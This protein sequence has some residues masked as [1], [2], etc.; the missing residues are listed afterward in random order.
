MF[1]EKTAAVFI[2]CRYFRG[3]VAG[4][5]ISCSCLAEDQ[6]MTESPTVGMTEQAAQTEQAVQLEQN[7]QAEQAMQAEQ[8]LDQAEESGDSGAD[9]AG[10]G[11]GE[12]AETDAAAAAGNS[13]DASA[14][15]LDAATQ[16][17]EAAS[18]ESTGAATSESTVAETEESA[19]VA[20]TEPVEEEKSYLTSPLTAEA[21]GL[22]VTVTPT[23]D[24]AL[25]ED[26]QLDV[27][28][29]T[30]SDPAFRGMEE[31]AE[32]TAWEQNGKV[33]DM[34]AAL[35][36]EKF[37]AISL[38][39]GDQEIEPQAQ[40]GVKVELSDTDASLIRD[41][42]SFGVLHYRDDEAVF[43][44]P[45]VDTQ[46]DDDKEENK[47][48]LFSFRAEDTADNNE[49]TVLSFDT[50]SFSDWGFYYTYTVDFYYD[51][52]RFS[53]PGEGETSL[54]EILKK[55]SLS[56][57]GKV[58]KAVYSSPEQLAVGEID[59]GN[60]T[61]KSL[62]P[63]TSSET[64]TLTTDQGTEYVIHVMDPGA[65]QE[66][67]KSAGEVVH[68]FDATVFY[69]GAKQEDGKYVWTA[70]SHA[71]DHRFSY[72]ISFGLGDEETGDD[73]VFAP[74]T[75]KITVPKTILV[76]REDK[77]ADHY[78]MS[79]PSMEEVKEAE[80]NGEEL[81][82]EVL[83][84]YKEDGDQLVITNIRDI[85]PGFDGFIEMSY[86]TSEET[87]AYK[88]MAPSK[89]FTATITAMDPSTVKDKDHPDGVWTE[90]QTKT[91]DSVYIDTQ[92]KLASME[93]RVP[94]K[95][96][97]WQSFWGKAP[98]TVK[99]PG[100][101]EPVNFDPDKYT[102]FVYEI[103]SRI[104]DNSQEYAVSVDDTISKLIADGKEV[105]QG[106]ETG[107]AAAW[108]NNKG[109]Y[110]IGQKSSEPNGQYEKESGL[111]YDYVVLAFDKTFITDT[112]KLEITNDTTETVHPRDD[113][114]NS[115][116]TSQTFRRRFVWNKPVFRGGGGGFGGWVRADGFYRYQEGRDEWP[117]EY[118]TELGNHAG[119]YSGYNL[120]DLTDDNNKSIS[121]LDFA[122]W[123][124]GYIGSWSVDRDVTNP[125]N[126]SKDNYYQEPVR[127]EV[128][129]NRFYLTDE[130]DGTSSAEKDRLTSSDDYQIDT[131]RFN[132]YARDPVYDENTA[133]FVGSDIVTYEDNEELV[134][135]VQTGT[136]EAQFVQAAVYNL[137]TG[138]FSDVVNSIITKTDTTVSGGPEIQF[139]DGVVGY[140]VTT[141]NKHYY[142][143]LGMVPSVS[144]KPSRRVLDVNKTGS[145]TESKTESFSL[146]NQVITTIYD[147]KNK[148]GVVTKP[149]DP[150]EFTHVVWGPA[151]AQDADFIRKVEKESSLTKDIVAST[152]L[153]KKKE[154]RVTWK[155]HADESYNFGQNEKGY[156]EQK[157][158]TFYDLLP[159]GAVL[160]PDSVLI[161]TNDEELP[162]S[163]FKVDTVA[164]NYNKTGRTLV[165]I[166]VYDAANWYD[167]YYDTVHTYE[168]IRDYGNE[169]YN[170][171]AYQTGNDSISDFYKETG[172]HTKENKIRQEFDLYQ[173]DT[174]ANPEKRNQEESL[175]YSAVGQVLNKTNEEVKT[176]SR[177]IF[178]G[179]DGDIAAIT[180]AA[181]GLSKKILS[182]R[183]SRYD[184]EAVVDN[185]GAYHYQLRFQNSY[186]NSSEKVVLYDA[187]EN[188]N[189]AG[190]SSDWKGEL[191]AIDFS[192]LPKD[193]NGNGLISPAIYYSTKEQ[194]YEGNQVP[195]LSDPVW[196]KLTLDKN[197]AVPE[198]LQK[199]IRAIAI[200][201]GTGTD[202]KAYQLDRGQALTVSLTMKAPAGASRKDGTAG[203]PEA[204][205]GVAVSYDRITDTSRSHRVSQVGC[206][207]AKL[208]ISRDVNIEKRSS[209]D[210]TVIRGIRFRLTET[211]DYGTAVDKILSTD[212]N[213]ELTFARV[214]KGTYTLMEYGSVPDWLDD[215]TAYTVKIDDNGRLWI[216]NPK[217]TD[218]PQEYVRTKADASDSAPFWFTV[219]NDPRIH[220]D[221]RFYKARQTTKDNDALTGIPDTTFELSGTSDYGND[222]VKTAISDSNGLV[223]LDNIEK[224]TYTLREIKANAD[225]I[226][227]STPYQVRVDEAGT[228]TLWKPVEAAGKTTAAGGLSNGTTVSASEG[229]SATVSEGTD[230]S[231]A[232]AVEET[233]DKDTADNNAAAAAVSYTA[234]D[235]IGEQLVIF[236]TPAY[237]DISFLKV[238]KDLP[239]RTLQGATFQ[240][241]G[242]NLANPENAESDANG[243]VTF[244]HL[245]SGSYV[246]KEIQA[247]AG[248][249]GE[250]KI[251]QENGVLNYTADASDYLIELKED[252]T[253]TI[254]KAD[255]SAVD[256]NDKSGSTPAADQGKT[257][258]SAQT[259]ELSKNADGDYLFP[260]ERALDGQIT[261][262]KKWEDDSDNDHRTA[263]VIHL[264]TSEN[265]TVIKGAKVVV[266]WIRDYATARPNTNGVTVTIVDMN[267]EE[268]TSSSEPSTTS[269]NLWIYKFP[270]VEL[271]PDQQYYVYESQPVS[272]IENG[273]YTGSAVTAENKT[274]LIHG[275]A[276]ISNTYREIYDFS[277][278]GRIQTFTA[279]KSGYYKLETWG[280][281]GGDYYG[282]RDDNIESRAGYG[283]YST[284]VIHLDKNKTIYVIVG[285]Q[286]KCDVNQSPAAYNGGGS[287]KG[288]G[289]WKA[290]G[291]GG[292]THMSFQANVAMEGEVWSPEGTIIVAGGGG[293]ADNGGGDGGNQRGKGIIDDGGGGDGGGTVGGNAYIN[294]NEAAGT[295]GGTDSTRYKYNKQGNGEPYKDG[296]SDSGAGGGGW[297]GGKVTNDKNGGA[298]GGS[299]YI[300]TKVLTDARTISGSESIPNPNGETEKGHFGNGFARITYISADSP[301]A[302]E[303]ADTSAGSTQAA[304]N[305][306]SYTTKEDGWVKDGSTWKYTLPVF[307]DTATYTYWEDPVEGYTS[308]AP[309]SKED[310]EKVE[311]A[312]DGS[313]S[314]T[315]V[316]TNTAD[317]AYGSLTVS[318]KVV[319]SNGNEL[320]D[321]TQ[322]FMFTLTLMGSRI[323]GT[324]SFGG[325]VFA[326]GQLTFTLHEGQSRTFDHIPAYTTYTVKEAE[327]AN[328]NNGEQLH[329]KSGN[330]T[331]G[332][333]STAEF[334]NTFTPAQKTRTDVK[335]IKK[336]EGSV[337]GAESDKYPFHAVLTGLD[338]DMEFSIQIGTE[339]GTDSGVQNYTTDAQGNADVTLS[340][341]SGET[342]VFGDLP[343]GA[344]YQFIEDA[345]K[346]TAR[347]EAVDEAGEDGV[348]HGTVLQT[349]GQNTAQNQ[350]LATQTETVEAGEKTIVTFTNTLAYTQQLTIKKTVK[351][352]GD[353]K[354]KDPNEK[355]EIT[356]T[357][358]GLKPGAKIDTDSV[359]YVTADDTGEA[360]KT[361]YLKDGQSAVFR[362]IPVSAKYQVKE[363]ANDYVGSYAITAANAKGD[364][365]TIADGNNSA[366]KKDLNT[367]E[368]II[369]RGENPTVELISGQR[370]SKVTIRKVDPDGKQLK[371][372]IF[373][374]YQGTGSNRKLYPDE[375]NAVMNLGEK[376]LTLPSGTYQLE[377]TKA[378]KGYIIE[379]SCK[380]ITFR[381]NADGT[382]TLMNADGTSELGADSAIYTM[383]KVEQ[384][385]NTK[386]PV[387]SITNK[388]GT[389]LPSTGGMD[390]RILLLLALAMIGSALWGF[391]QLARDGRRKE[392]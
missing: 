180:S 307:D 129:D 61:V 177:L 214:E 155:I 283:G 157:S 231:E 76:D 301:T 87:F 391:R 126:A 43:V 10:E 35:P 382:V 258:D 376:T 106:K 284:G 217:K 321:S 218:K 3:F 334:T 392:R 121:G 312:I 249:N 275:K 199:E 93:E 66:A 114:D 390:V 255:N 216:T 353:A 139:K 265:Q 124:E 248:V 111:R 250:G 159:V 223:K 191:T 236:N 97:K 324:Q 75:V 253:Y 9:P 12:Q 276:T 337:A 128:T 361:F 172:E 22:K 15:N 198:N 166:T 174:E 118:F 340:L 381:V 338:P 305:T 377:E 161:S 380:S 110:A 34:S 102:Y 374:L 143:R 101:T 154:Y 227:N 260:D 311:A 230:S 211:S 344:Q 36:Y 150:D 331:G 226:L 65:A 6:L 360:V 339:D 308:D 209:K 280:A 204:Y 225:Y 202:G 152:N 371:G 281:S 294:G 92:V 323:S 176:D 351:L 238:D 270:D 262:I 208:V 116:A 26:T 384:D 263:P 320:K 206:T 109:S 261:I 39:E 175:L 44:T 181:S 372:A 131:L 219:Y 158:G 24:A 63:F 194:N 134:F 89:E 347:F 171:V 69:G 103:C 47:F 370:W 27:R 322:D 91:V 98:A 293:G 278:T 383:V 48:Q 273:K 367:K 90:Q 224:G 303:T 289:G 205:N 287:A 145:A 162:S 94:A 168:S 220:A 146:N 348:T 346:W 72:R 21:G 237:W 318:K 368:Q 108:Y 335:L 388:A 333:T 364:V 341:K 167:L 122:V 188:Y 279:S 288:S 196:N 13:S 349:S 112:N 365:R 259:G 197:G 362:N 40:V 182:D 296:H 70:R 244:K 170:S 140:R 200:D 327:N 165:K 5:G 235:T 355:F 229:N 160:D 271:H 300:D 86:L 240:L 267:G 144:L 42:V 73:M 285:E 326:N 254:R 151:A 164:S 316:V 81:D 251:D 193:E 113:A 138:A 79:V 215:H 378:P 95:Y 28:E 18:S 77:Q 11:K 192:A 100:V 71:K 78:E 302:S 359:G 123:S 32:K 147:Y 119:N 357:I 239:T 389:R 292:M 132:I 58:V 82:K 68:D 1:Y 228:A 37:L 104:G 375:K 29:I 298:G 247:P 257:E 266:E 186:S 60:C 25:P 330:I 386:T 387:I 185:N 195:A 336:T 328:Y 203:Y 385:E 80:D 272:N 256:Q 184:S 354:Q 14:G 246:M 352:D 232:Q 252:G 242:V 83:F 286:G 50:E 54:D 156:V 268:I 169:A 212:R 16:E 379:Q 17:S 366:A 350:T 135:E 7:L 291:G 153:Q 243:R 282:Y 173:S 373:M 74:G 358:T 233:D 142:F 329:D 23:E 31:Q 264:E 19:D 201:L 178:R 62:Q 56:P 141:K 120:N 207:T 363:T 33:E 189:N 88:D 148:D 304:S 4:A 325:N 222:V 190:R 210:N 133:Q 2:I 45:Q 20:E 52:Q 105:D 241:S 221:L 59:D 306:S 213:G 99:I 332:Q 274:P 96:D 245:K 295:G 84:A 49:H 309:A 55:L 85:E 136:T 41:G 269:G 125:N 127:Y 343:E 46:S 53:L 277:Y 38:K 187:L 149:G 310:A 107:F 297:F 313:K 317:S 117:R 163:S 8:T 319:D 356:V 290:C 342:A 315:L 179:R 30:S 369:T 137:E 130:N 183:S 51:G 299:G 64:L 345:G 234:A 115:Q 57:D 67:P 314:K